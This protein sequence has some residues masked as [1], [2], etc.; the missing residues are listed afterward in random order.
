MIYY[1]NIFLISSVFGFFMESLLKIFLFHS[2]NNGIMFGPWIPIYGIG[3]VVITFGWNLIMDMK[4]IS[5]F[6][7][8]II[9]LLYSF[10]ILTLLEYIGGNL[11]E[12][13]FHKIYWDYSGLL[14]NFGHYI[15]LEMSFLWGICSLIYVYFLMRIFDKIEKKI[16]VIISIL[17]SCLFIIDLILTI[18]FQLVFCILHQYL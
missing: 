8:N 12:I 14:F 9:L 15:S 1:I 5:F 6:K 3:V 10:F 16:P 7:K 2:M 13:I 17:V 4:G 18:N 11:I